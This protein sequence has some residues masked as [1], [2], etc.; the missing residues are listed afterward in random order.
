MVAFLAVF[1]EVQTDGLDF[2]AGAEAGA[3][4]ADDLGQNQGGEDG[5]DQHEQTGFYLFQPKSATD[6]ALDAVRAEVALPEVEGAPTS[7]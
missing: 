4:D 5:P 6:Q 2:I 1:G 3:D 7:L